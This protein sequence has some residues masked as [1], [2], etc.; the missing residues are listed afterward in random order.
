MIIRRQTGNFHFEEDPYNKDAR[1]IS[2]SYHEVLFLMKFLQTMPEV[3][4]M[5]KDYH[6]LYYTVNKNR[7]ENEVVDDE[8]ENIEI[9]YNNFNDFITPNH[10]IGRKK[11]KE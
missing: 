8:Y 6:N 9:E 4:S 5:D 1:G 11:D 2:K 7:D 10:Y 3:K